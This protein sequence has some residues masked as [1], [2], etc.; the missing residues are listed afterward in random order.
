MDFCPGNQQAVQF[1][2][3]DIFRSWRISA[4]RSVETQYL[5]RM[6]IIFYMKNI[7][8][9]MVSQAMDHYS[10][11]C[12][13][14]SLGCFA[15]VLE[16]TTWVYPDNEAIG[17]LSHYVQFIYYHLWF[18]MIFNSRSDMKESCIIYKFKWKETYILINIDDLKKH[19]SFVV[20]TLLSDSSLWKDITPLI[21]DKKYDWFFFFD[22]MLFWYESYWIRL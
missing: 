17:I 10:C 14:N 4:G 5:L 20:W 8:V 18:H 12:A 16:M 1:D 21:V 13:L 3:S 2:L 9:V 22:L 19:R 6:R 15:F 7:I 11:L